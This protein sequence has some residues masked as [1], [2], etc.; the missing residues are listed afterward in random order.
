MKPS[1]QAHF[2]CGDPDF[3]AFTGTASY[4]QAADYVRTY[5]M[6]SSRADLD[7]YANPA[8]RWRELDQKFIERSRHD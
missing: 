2:R 6:V 8:A 7:K 4:D 3:Q 5:C 1:Q